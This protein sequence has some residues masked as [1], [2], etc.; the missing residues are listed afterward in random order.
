[1]GGRREAGGEGGE[2]KKTGGGRRN[3][4]VGNERRGRGKS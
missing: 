2:G 3:M 1:M 4:S